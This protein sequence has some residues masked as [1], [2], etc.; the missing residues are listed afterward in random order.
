[1]TKYQVASDNYITHAEPM[2]FAELL[3]FFNEE[4]PTV[5]IKE[6]SFD[7]ENVVIDSEYGYSDILAFEVQ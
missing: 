4:H 3:D 2:T 6:A 7:N 5:F 1:M